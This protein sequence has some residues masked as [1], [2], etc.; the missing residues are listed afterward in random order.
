DFALGH[1]RQH[2]DGVVDRA[3]DQDVVVLAR[4]AQHPAHDPVLVARMADADA[5][6]VEAP[7][8]QQ[9]DGVAQSIL[10][11]MATVEL[12]PRRTRRQV[13]LVVDQQRLF[14]LDLPEP[15]RGGDRL[16]G[17]V[18]EGGGLEQPD[19]LAADVH[20]RGLAEQLRLQAEAHALP[21]GQGID[22][23]E[24]GVV[25]VERVF[26][27]GIAQADDETN[28]RHRAGNSR[29]PAR[30][31]PGGTLR[32]YLASP[33]PA[34]GA[35]S[36]SPCA[37]LATTTATSW[38]G[39]RA[40]AGI[41]TPVGS[42]RPD[43]WTTPPTARSDRSTSIASG[44]SFGRQATL[45]SVSSCMITTPAVLPAGDLASLTKRSGT[46]ARSTSSSLTRWKS[47]CMICCLYGWRC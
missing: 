32:A 46:A 21:L 37:C 2:V 10:A 41:S 12:Q 38:S 27:A 8:A 42:F 17:E 14:R 45:T 1:Q 16:A 34:A 29:G 47:R 36:A 20:P 26:R 18:H 30:H 43:R 23:A 19:L 35:S 44:R 9:A 7:V 3:P 24:A 39:P 31:Q 15:Q 22:Q 33:S 11:A 13:E 4:L 40:R 28:F 6:A 25:P 5:Q